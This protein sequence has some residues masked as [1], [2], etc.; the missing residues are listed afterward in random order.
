MAKKKQDREDTLA[1]VGGGEIVAS[2]P[3]FMRD[4]EVLGTGEIAS[5]IIPPFV[6]I[7]QRQSAAELVDEFGMG[8]IILT[9]HNFLVAEAPDAFPGEPLL[10]NPLL[11]WKEYCKWNDINLRGSAPAVLERSFD[12]GSSV[13]R[14]ARNPET[15]KETVEGKTFMYVE[16]L[17]FLCRIMNVP[18]LEDQRVMFSFQRAEYTSGSKLCSLISMRKGPIYGMQFQLRVNKHKNTQYSWF[19]F[20]PENP[21]PEVGQPWI[22]D[23][24]EYAAM[25]DEH[26][27]FR[28]LYTA[29]KLNA[30][31]EGD[32]A[33]TP[34]EG[35]F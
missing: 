32:D 2:M 16:H 12:I 35:E 27:S 14:K 4:E 5:G 6:K 34:A 23:P 24:E 29:G 17:N 20:D 13:A 3:D 18:G 7:V 31:Y 26:E 11:F 33:A 15:R 10:I 25:R 19:G 8:A 1:K 9:P 21:H 30:A 22:T 28:G